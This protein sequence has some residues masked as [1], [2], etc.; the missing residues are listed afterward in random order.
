MFRYEGLCLLFRA[1]PDT[2]LRTHGVYDEFQV[3][4]N[5]VRSASRSGLTNRIHSYTSIEFTLI[6]VDGAVFTD[7]HDRALYRAVMLESQR[8]RPQHGV[9]EIPNPSEAVPSSN[10][11]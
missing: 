9:T 8:A 11:Q 7:D 2:R 1:S 5:F 10:L 4:D 3:P 6:S